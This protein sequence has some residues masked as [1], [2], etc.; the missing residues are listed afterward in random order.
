MTSSNPQWCDQFWWNIFV[1][2]R[3]ILINKKTDFY[4]FKKSKGE[5]KLD[6]TQ[7]F[8]DC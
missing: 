5:T 1:N 4:R 8:S 2:K 7:L 6:A 3:G